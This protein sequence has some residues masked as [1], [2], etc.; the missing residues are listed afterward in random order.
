LKIRD[1]LF[2]L[3]LS[4]SYNYYEAVGSSANRKSIMMAASFAELIQ[5]DVPTLVLF[6]NGKVM[7]RQAGVVTTEH[8][9]RVIDQHTS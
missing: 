4:E 3:K 8:L 6:K 2:N 1:Q 7:W 9:K 5:S